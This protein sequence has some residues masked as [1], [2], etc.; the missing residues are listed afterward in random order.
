MSH[1]KAVKESI[2]GSEAQGLE[3]KTDRNGSSFLGLSAPK[4]ARLM[5]G[6]LY[7]Q[8]VCKPKVRCF[9]RTVGKLQHAALPLR[10]PLAVLQTLF[11]L[12]Q[13]EAGTP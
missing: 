3:I 11:F 5:R 9:Q 10:H 4:R 6:G 2:C 7:L 8:G 12:G 1:K 13:T